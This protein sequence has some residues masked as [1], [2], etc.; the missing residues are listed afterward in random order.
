MVAL[1]D[2]ILISALMYGAVVY[3]EINHKYVEGGLI[4]PFL[5]RYWFLPM[6]CCGCLVYGWGSLS[7]AIP[8]G[9]GHEGHYLGY[10]ADFAGLQCAS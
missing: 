6:L 1:F 3:W 2:G 7:G 10:G 8:G 9:E 4:L 5:R